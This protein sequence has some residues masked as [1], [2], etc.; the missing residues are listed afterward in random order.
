MNFQLWDKLCN[1]KKFSKYL[2]RYD[3]TSGAD[4]RKQ[5]DTQGLQFQTEFLGL[6]LVNNLSW[7]RITYFRKLKNSQIWPGSKESVQIPN[8]L[9]SSSDRCTFKSSL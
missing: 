9:D 6:Q 7:T 1:L 3:K 5:D 4:L 8:I 2:P